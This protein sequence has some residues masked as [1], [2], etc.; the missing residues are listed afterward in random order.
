MKKTRRPTTRP[1]KR[2]QG[3]PRRPAEAAATPAAP[4]RELANPNPLASLIPTGSR[5]IGYRPAATG[6]YRGT[7]EKL[8]ILDERAATGRALHSPRDR[9][10][11]LD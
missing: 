10:P 7:R 1:R 3:K 11:D 6:E 4:P 8:A 5:R 2:G 9:Q